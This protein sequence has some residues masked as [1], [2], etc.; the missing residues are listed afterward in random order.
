MD[1]Y[2][3]VFIGADGSEDAD[4]AIRIAGQIAARLDVP[5]TVVTAWEGDSD[6]PGS[7]DYEWA[8]GVGDAAVDQLR[9]LGVTDVRQDQPTGSATDILLKIATDA[10]DS[11]LAIGARGLSSPTSRLTGSLS[12][13]LSHHSP[14]DLLLARSP[15]PSQWQSV[16][17]TTDGSATSRIA[18]R[19]GLAVA[20][21]LG[22]TPHIVTVAKDEAEGTRLMK[23]ALAE[24][25]L[26][27]PD[28]TVERD[29]LLGV[30]ASKALVE[31][32]RDYDLMVIGNR[33]MSGRSR[34]LGSIANKVTH[35]AECPLLLVNT[36][37]E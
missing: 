28:L 18:V 25:E 13:H 29:V 27:Q 10:P 24:I 4:S 26:C 16:G 35:S 17:L 2:P 22:A 8:R 36:T 14:A 33:S 20:L 3:Q 19:R 31:A 5:A 6:V 37:R 34:L 15:V 21:A 32:S 7:Q 23:S 11:L 12:N 1:S 9:E 30:L